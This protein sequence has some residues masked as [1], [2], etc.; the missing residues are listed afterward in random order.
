[1]KT[2]T[3]ILLLSL[4]LLVAIGGF[5]LKTLY[6]AGEF[7]TLIPIN[8][9][10][11]SVVKGV[12]SSEDIVIHPALGIAFISSAD[13]R[14][15][16]LGTKSTQGAIYA[17]DLR[18]KN[19]KLVNLTVG[20]SKPL[21]PHGLSLFIDKKGK[22]SLFVVNH[23]TRKEHFIEI[24]DY[25]NEKLIHRKSVADPLMHSPNDVIGVSHEAFYVSNDHGAVSTL[26]RMVEEYLQLSRSY[27]LYYN[28]KKFR[29]VAQGI[30]YANGVSISLDKKTIY[31]A[32][33]VGQKIL[34]YTRDLKT[35]N[36]SLKRS[37]KVGTGVDNIA[38][39]SKGK[40]WVGC[41]PKLLTFTFHAKNPDKLS[42][43]EI[44][45]IDPKKSGA[46]SIKRLYMSKGKPLSASSVAVPYQNKVLIGAVIDQ[47][48][49]V[50]QQK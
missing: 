28:G 24:F 5:V 41:H 31:V 29:K 4:L 25:K 33:T 1:M 12:L 50:C 38:I 11:C 36:L 13:R 43:S 44:I 42:P 32:A 27:L 9:A 14:A 8:F 6:N 35:G 21:F 17:Y 45:I 20:F 39:D 49:L 18:Q 3:K 34:A 16:I 19:A 48:F 10:K 30:G 22:S 15:L 2:R 23:R 26:W 47:R 40:L 7:K 46:S 37:F